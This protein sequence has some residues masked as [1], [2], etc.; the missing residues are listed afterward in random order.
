MRPLPGE[1]PPALLARIY[2]LFPEVWMSRRK[3]RLVLL[4][5]PERLP[6]E[7]PHPFWPALWQE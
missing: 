6:G 7:G 3:G 5:H 4:K 2:W 1:V